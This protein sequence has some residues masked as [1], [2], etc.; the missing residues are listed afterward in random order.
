[1]ESLKRM[2][3]WEGH[4]DT[5]VF[6]AFVKTLGIYPVGSLVR[7]QS[8]R[9]AVVLDQHKDS[10]L[11]PRVKVFFSAKSNTHLPQEIVDISKRADKIV[12]R[13]SPQ[14]WK[15]PN[16]DELWTGLPSTQW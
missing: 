11:T 1:A 7:L 13:E 9:L 3:S 5:K 6:Q 10:L 8:G 16:F 14:N 12:G 2:A 4:F 15:F